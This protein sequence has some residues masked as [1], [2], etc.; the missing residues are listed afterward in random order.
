MI[1][2]TGFCCVIFERGRSSLSHPGVEI[3]D[4][5]ISRENRFIRTLKRDRYLYVMTAIGVIWMFIFNYIPVYGIVVAFKRYNVVD[6]IWGSQWVGLHNFEM[7]FKNPYFFRLVRN[8]VLLGLYSTLWGFWPPI[9]LALLLNELRSKT[10][11]RVI[12]TVSYLPHFI[13]TVIIVGMLKDFFSYKGI[14]NQLLK[15][16]GIGTINFF[17][18]PNWFRTLYIGSG[19]WQGVGFSSIIYLAVLSSVNPELYECA[20]MEGAN[21]FQQAIYITIPSI[22]PT[23]MILLILSTTGIVNVGFE[24]VYLMYSP[25]IYKTADV[26]QTY[27]YRV[28][29][30][31]GQISFGSAVG[32]FNHVISLIFMVSAN[33]ISRKTTEYSMW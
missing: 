16:L 32:L 11:K 25:A 30:E 17:S 19:I 6:G 27:T 1:Y 5:G 4:S 15:A 12:Q 31:G 2:N 24:K 29:L 23:I 9:L 10:Y 28:G 8:T 7:F 14:V 21:R 3:K 20:S 13:A 26:I 18:D 22:L 33:Y